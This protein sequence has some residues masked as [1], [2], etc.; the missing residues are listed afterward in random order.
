MT[1]LVPY[2][3][4]EQSALALEYAVAT[5]GD[6]GLLLAHVIEPFADHTGAGGYDPSRYEA[7]FES[8]ESMVEEVIDS[9]PDEIN[10]KTEIRYGRPAQTIRRIAEET[11]TDS[12]VIGSH[13]RDGVKRVLLGSI[14]ETVLRRVSVPVTIVREREAEGAD[15]TDET[16]SSA[17]TDETEGVAQTD[18]TDLW[19]GSPPETVLVPFDGSTPAGRALSHAITTYPDAAITA[20]YVTYPPDE[21]SKSQGTGVSAVLEDWESRIDEHRDRILSLA[22]DV[23]G[24]HETSIQTASVPG[25]PARVIV[26]YASEHD[27]DHILMGSQGRDGIARILLGSVAETVARRAPTPVTVVR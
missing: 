10:V 27:V 16:E 20:L 19:A 23:A 21:I 14:A 12:I 26:E 11:G 17:D 7:A 24:E 2:D 1:I 8:A 4:S 15:K 9:L 13:G 18:K 3:G 25:D 5:A 22:E 6:E